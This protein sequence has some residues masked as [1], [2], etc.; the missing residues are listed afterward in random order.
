[1]CH[2]GQET[3]SKR[4]STLLAAIGRSWIQL[5]GA[6]ESFI[7]D[8]EGGMTSPYSVEEIKRRG[9][10][11]DMRARRQR[12]R[13]IER[14]GAML[15]HALHAA[16]EQ[17][18]CEGI[19][20]NFDAMHAQSVFAG[21]GLTNVGGVTPY[22]VVF[23]QQPSMLPPLEADDEG[24]VRPMAPVPNPLLVVKSSPA[25]CSGASAR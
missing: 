17:L 20:A 12:A 23:G 15:R 16:E 6:M 7:V 5:F 19:A 25:D 1:M 24:E 18:G 9:V 11:V 22:N 10:Q 2:N 4:D 14:R 21:N 3:A 13:F 8:G